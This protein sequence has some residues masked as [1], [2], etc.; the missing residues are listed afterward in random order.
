MD[1]YSSLPYLSVTVAPMFAGKSSM[2]LWELDRAAAIYSGK[3]ICFLHGFDDRTALTTGGE[4]TSV[5]T[6]SKVSRHGAKEIETKKVTTLHDQTID[7]DVVAIGVDEAQFFEA[8][9]L[10][11]TVLRWCSAGKEAYP[12]LRAVFVCG[13]DGDARQVPFKGCGIA[14]LLPI[15]ESFVKLK[16]A[17]CL[18]CIHLG[19]GPCQASFTVRKDTF[20]DFDETAVANVGGFNEYEAVCRVHAK[21]SA[22]SIFSSL[23]KGEKT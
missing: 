1:S 18:R 15:A 22:S 10:Y 7:A 17:V 2:L 21:E 16:T 5:S 23:L 3:A 19:L 12:N 6:H 13:L 9:D 4:G 20:V 11:E 14:S 8:K